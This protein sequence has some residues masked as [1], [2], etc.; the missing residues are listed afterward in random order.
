MYGVNASHLTP[1]NKRELNFMVEIILDS[2]VSI[3]T[4][5]KVKRD[6]VT[7]GK[8]NHRNCSGVA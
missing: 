6:E 5:M 8:I 4:P 1:G 3:Q 2:G 7:N